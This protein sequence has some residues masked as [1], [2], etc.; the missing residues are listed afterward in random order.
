MAQTP[1]YNRLGMNFDTEKFGEANVLGEKTL[2]FL[3]QSRID[4]DTWQYNDIANNT[5]SRTEYF[6]N[7]LALDCANVKS[8]I[9]NIVISTTSTDYANSWPNAPVEAEQLFNISTSL[10]IAIDE[11]K[12]HTDNISGL[13]ILMTSAN[14][15]CY[16]M[17]L[18]I[19]TEI[20]RLTV[21]QEDIAN[22]SPMLG[23]MT[24]LFVGPELANSTIE[25]Y[26]DNLTINANTTLVVD[27]ETS[28]ANLVCN[29]SSNIVNVIITHV[30]NAYTLVE[31]RRAHDY[32]FYQNSR[33]V[34]ND[35]MMTSRFS[36]VGNTQSFLIN[37]YIGTEK[38]KNSI[39]NT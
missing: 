34:L 39:A 7:P 15:P 2:N 38:L 1:I 25:L 6:K 21:S 28:E 11:F 16:D 12:T 9:S 26:N 29:L 14:V 36:R 37:N 4:L 20:L 27:P 13:N 10:N 32:A 24:S 31:G 23:S 19:G 17:I 22:A 35:M 30:T 8:S 3:K 33:D 5:A 18:S